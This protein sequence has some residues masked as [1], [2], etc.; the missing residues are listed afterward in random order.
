MSNRKRQP[1]REGGLFIV[2]NRPLA[3][4]FYILK[5]FFTICRTIN[6]GALIY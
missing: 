3:K 5:D 4:I 2:L 6:K 1:T